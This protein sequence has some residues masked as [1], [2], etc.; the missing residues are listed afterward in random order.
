MRWIERKAKSTRRK[1]E[2]EFCYGI[3][4]DKGKVLR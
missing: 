2:S 3:M 4:L 1:K